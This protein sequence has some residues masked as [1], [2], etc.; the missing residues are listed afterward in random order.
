MILEKDV[1]FV[2][3]NDYH[4]DISKVFSLLSSEEHIKANSFVFEQ[5]RR[6]YVLAHAILRILISR[7]LSISPGSISFSY[8]FYGKPFCQNYRNFHFNMSHSGNYVAYIFSFNHEVG[9][10]IEFIKE[11]FPLESLILQV[12]SHS[13]RKVF[14]KLTDSQKIDFFYDTWTLK[15][16]FLKAV[17]VGLSYPLPNLT[18][19]LDQNTGPRLQFSLGSQPSL[20]DFNTWTFNTF[21]T[22]PNYSG[23]ISIHKENAL[24]KIQSFD[25]S[26]LV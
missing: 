7:Y 16:S 22:L 17:S 4:D 13:E 3:S 12:M 6:R 8:T 1:Y 19:L 20:F 10:D 26:S 23:A 9:I 5:L 14:H 24:F 2:N 18:T 21:K 11:D 25:F 15:E